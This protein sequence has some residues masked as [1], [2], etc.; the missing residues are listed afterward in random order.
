MDLPGYVLQTLFNLFLFCGISLILVG[1]KVLKPMCGKSHTQ[2][3]IAPPCCMN[4]DTGYFLCLELNI[5]LATELI[6]GSFKYTS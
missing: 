2:Q 3:D 1:K 6:S 4:M 5:P